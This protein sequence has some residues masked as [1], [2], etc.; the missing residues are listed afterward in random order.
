MSHLGRFSIQALINTREAAF[1]RAATP[2]AGK[3]RAADQ[4]VRCR[5]GSCSDLLT[6]RRPAAAS[7][8]TRPRTSR[9]PPHVF[10]SLLHFWEVVRI[11]NFAVCWLYCSLTWLMGIFS[12]PSQVC[13]WRLLYHFLALVVPWLSL[14]Y[15]TRQGSSSG[16][17]Y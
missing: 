10:V 6:C 8:V 9:A 11:H 17:E 5:R 1:R 14:A 7:G 15:W 3:S 12:R 16:K 2:K 4:T 13:F